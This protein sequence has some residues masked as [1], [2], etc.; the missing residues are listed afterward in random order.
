M[1]LYK[2]I[3]GLSPI[4]TNP[5]VLDENHHYQ[6]VLREAHGRKHS[7]SPETALPA[8]IFIIAFFPLRR[9]KRSSPTR[10]GH[11]NIIF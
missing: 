7:G 4:T 1:V 11:L 9:P 8:G 10:K 5:L 3:G 6:F 2:P